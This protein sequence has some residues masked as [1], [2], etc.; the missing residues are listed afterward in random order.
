M[1][2]D[3]T[4]IA[5]LGVIVVVAAALWAL[6]RVFVRR[7]TGWAPRHRVATVVDAREDLVILDP[8]EYAR[9][10][11]EITLVWD[12]GSARVGDPWSHEGRIARSLLS[13]DGAPPCGEVVVSPDPG[14]DPGSAGPFIDVSVPTDIGAMPAWLYGEETGSWAIH[15]HGVRSRRLNALWS[16]PAATSAGFRSLVIAYRGSP[17][18]QPTRGYAGLGY[19]EADDVVA[20]VDYAIT[21]GAER[22]VLFG[23]SMGASAALLASESTRVADRLIGMVLIAPTVSWRHVMRAGAARMR[24]PML[25]SRAVEAVVQSRTLARLSGLSMP[26]S[27]DALDWVTR[28]GRLRVPAL[29]FA[30]RGDTNVPFELVELFADA[31]PGMVRVREVAACRHGWE[32]NVDPA[33]FAKEVEEWLADR[34]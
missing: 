32:P 14:T 2:A 26:V 13:T 3:V 12:G 9:E 6:V 10:P 27:L 31:N 15:V 24:M 5:V 4:L 1:A 25:V 28:S 18:G 23:W 8:S 22:I 7:M 20:A 16:V 33:V 34:P 30:S 19:A 21:H 11:G 17:D 29:V